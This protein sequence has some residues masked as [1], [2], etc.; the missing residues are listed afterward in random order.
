MLLYGAFFMIKNLVVSGC[1]FTAVENARGH[2][3]SKVTAEHFGL[4]YHNL[5]HV[6]AGNTYIC[7]SVIDYLEAKQFDPAETLVL[8]MWSGPSR[9]DLRVSYEYWNSLKTYKFKFNSAKYHHDSYYVGSC[10]RSNA[11]YENSDAKQLFQM[12]Y[13]SSD[14]ATICKD[15]LV[16]FVNLDDYLKVR[17]YNYKFTSF[18]NQWQEDIECTDF[19]EYILEYYVKD[20]PIYKNFNFNSWF[21][22]NESKDSLWEYAKQ[23]Q[24]LAD[25]GFHPSVEAHKQFAQEYVIPIIEGYIK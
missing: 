3:W 9:K 1:S 20:L 5:A 19:G 18:Y 7:N 21:F 14:P 23:H 4:T 2:P 8:A 10:G 24:L 16:N 11:W 25:D 12:M 17:G 22:I 13:L 6:G 15:S